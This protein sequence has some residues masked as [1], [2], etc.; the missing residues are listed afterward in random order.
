MAF[1]TLKTIVFQNEKKTFQLRN[2]VLFIVCFYLVSLI[3]V[4]RRHF[5]CQGKLSKRTGGTK[6]NV[7]KKI[8]MNLLASTPVFHKKKVN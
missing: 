7:L 3:K 4:L 2:F 5:F 1:T 6:S 8:V